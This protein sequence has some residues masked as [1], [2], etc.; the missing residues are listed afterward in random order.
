MIAIGRKPN[1]EWVPIYHEQRSATFTSLIVTE[2]E[3]PDSLLASLMASV[4]K[5]GQIETVSL[6]TRL[7]IVESR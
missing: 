3:L 6:D 1:G 4:P 5:G 7:P 2:A